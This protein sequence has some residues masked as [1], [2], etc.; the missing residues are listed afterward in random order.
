MVGLEPAAALGRMVV[1][2]LFDRLQSVG[3]QS[4]SYPAWAR[5]LFDATFALIL[6]S[7]FVYALLYG[8]VA[9]S[10]EH[11]PEGSST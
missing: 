2:D 6:V 4:D 8:R 10:E 7:A 9:R 1:A 3:R 5:V 11:D